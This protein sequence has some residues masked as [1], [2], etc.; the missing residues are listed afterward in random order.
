MSVLRM[1][2]VENQFFDE[3]DP[4]ASPSD[5]NGSNATPDTEYSPPHS[6]FPKRR[7]LQ[8][9]RSA[10]RKKLAQLTI[11]EKVCLTAKRTHHQLIMP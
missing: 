2:P 3:I 1:E 4:L 11:E 5:S 8:D 6:P 7:V 9:S 10:A